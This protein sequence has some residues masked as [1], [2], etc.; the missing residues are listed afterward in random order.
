MVLLSV[1]NINGPRKVEVKFKITNY[2]WSWKNKKKH[3]GTVTPINIFC[4]QN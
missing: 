3:A 2:V 4:Y 1:P